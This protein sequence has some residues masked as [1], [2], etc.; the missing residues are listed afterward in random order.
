M[1]A[2]WPVGEVGTY[3][4][5]A[6]YAYPPL[7]GRSQD[8]CRG[9]SKPVTV[10]FAVAEDGGAEGGLPL[11][12]PLVGGITVVGLVTAL[13]RWPWLPRPPSQAMLALL[14]IVSTGTAALGIPSPAEATIPRP[15]PRLHGPFDVCMQKFRAEGGSGD[16]AG[17]IPALEFSPRKVVI[18]PSGDETFSRPDSSSITEQEAWR[19]ATDGSGVDVEVGWN[20]N[21][22]GKFMDGTP[23]ERCAEL[24]HELVHAYDYAHGAI[25]LHSCRSVAPVEGQPPLQ[26]M[27]VKATLAENVYRRNAG[28]PE[29]TQYG[30]NK[31]PRTL[32]E[33]YKGRNRDPRTFPKIPGPTRAECPAP[34]CAGSD[35]DPHLVTFD[36]QRYDLQAAGEFT[37]VRSTTDSLEIQ[38]R[39]TPYPGSTL[40]SINKAVAMD[41]AGDR[42]GLYLDDNGIGVRVNGAHAQLLE[43]GLGLPAG[44]RLSRRSAEDLETYAVAWPDGSILTAHIVGTWGLN[45]QVQ[46]AESRAAAVRG[47][48]GDFDGNPDNDLTTSTGQALPRDPSFD[49]V[50][51]EFGESW[52]VSQADSLFDYEP[53]EDTG[54]FTLRDF[55]ERP[56]TTEDLPNQQ[57]A[58]MLCQAAGVTAGPYLDA[59]MIDAAVTGQARFVA[60]AANTPVPDTGTDLLRDGELVGGD[61]TSPK[62][63]RRYRVDLSGAKNFAIADWRGTSDGCDQTF[64]INF[65]GISENNFPCTGGY[66]EFT[67]PDPAKPYEVEIASSSDGSGSYQFRLITM[68]PRTL[69]TAVGRTVNAGHLDVRGREDI[70]AFDPAGAAAIRL[71]QLPSCEANMLAELRDVTT[72]AVVTANNPMCGSELGPY[73]LPNPQHRYAVVIRSSNLTTGRY[74]FKLEAGD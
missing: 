60:S 47:L 3:E 19:R 12:W 74:T 7:A 20:P 29:R 27:E 67:A 35:G 8:V 1:R 68:K 61:I 25:D 26:N 22:S 32:D 48:F 21:D 58:Q 17:I 46:L 66:A 38:V 28:L 40:V 42:V 62:Q 55:P 51:G 23:K 44:G 64:R 16:P 45:V 33:C 10:R 39:Q 69:T 24:Y 49:Q 9:A 73:Q 71:T 59:C 50:Y 2:L 14:L 31:L 13:R 43:Q 56:I 41:V 70:H 5:T 54:T 52:R 15:N 30:P 18:K 34:G 65:V 37:A 53:R 72:G 57:V 11:L 6:V 63:T 36:G 4:V